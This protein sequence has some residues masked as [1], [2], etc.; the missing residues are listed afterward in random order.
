M[1]NNSTH[2]ERYISNVIG[3]KYKDWKISNDSWEGSTRVFL[4]SPTGTGKTYFFTN[5][6]LKHAI[7]ESRSIV[8]VC[9]RS[10]L[11]DQIINSLR[12]ADI[13]LTEMPSES[14]T[15]LWAFKYPNSD[16]YLVVFNYQA[17]TQSFLETINY[18]A[19][20]YVFF[21]EVHFFLDDACF[22]PHTIS[23]YKNLMWK[24]KS[25]VQIFTS[26]TMAEFCA[27]YLETY[28]YI[29]APYEP[30]R[31][32]KLKGFKSHIEYYSNSYSLKNAY[33]IIF[34]TEDQFLLDEIKKSS[35]EEKWLIF[36]SQIKRGY[37]L[38]MK[39][40]AQG[41]RC[42]MLSS[43]NKKSEIW[44]NLVEKNTFEENVLLTTNVIYNGISISEDK[45][46]NIVIPLTPYTEF[47]QRL[48][49]KRF[50]DDTPKPINLYVQIPTIRT[51]RKIIYNCN[52]ELDKY[53]KLKQPLTISEKVDILRYDSNK[54]KIGVEYDLY[55]RNNTVYFHTNLLAV[56]HLYNQI[57]FYTYL[58]KYNSLGYTFYRELI[59][60]RLGN[61]ISEFS[62]GSFKFSLKDLLEYHLKNPVEDCELFY[63]T[64]LEVYSHF[65]AAMLNSNVISRDV[66]DEIINL[67]KRKGR[68]LG[69]INRA[70]NNI[71]DIN[72][73]LLPYVVKKKNNTWV[74]E[75][76]E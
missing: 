14:K 36:V 16:N 57:D 54:N 12:K 27:F 70:L 45:L 28:D 56:K 11:R 48:G 42:G 74:V 40:A 21:D 52:N 75:R 31:A 7:E 66:F 17:A 29:V 73:S 19:P 13:N 2:N 60:R 5:F 9:N 49:R 26:A 3:E 33:N 41:K 47:I 67:K 38:G 59:R 4:E 6:L 24:Y 72:S 53:Q 65:C 32:I 22:N 46:K 1:D 69:T 30:T 39:I 61:S 64:F 15:N 25:Q 43:E 10:G 34:F 76:K 71:R 62:N 51:I 50:K 58:K 44:Q 63:K 23:I 8:Y 35:A 20:Y 18:P 68:E 37:E 55:V